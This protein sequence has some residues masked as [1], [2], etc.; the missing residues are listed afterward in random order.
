MSLRVVFRRPARDEFQEAALWYEAQRSGL[1]AA[2]RAAIDQAISGIIENP[3]RFP[4][5]LG[6]VRCARVS[7]FPYS[8]FFLIESTRLVVLA[9]FHAR[10]DPADWQSRA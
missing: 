9:V 6:D 7:R 5:V 2:F 1:G 4:R 3:R 8:V 10:R